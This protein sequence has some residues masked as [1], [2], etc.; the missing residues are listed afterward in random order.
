[1]TD[2]AG[3]TIR[4]EKRTFAAGTN[5]FDWRIEDLSAGMY[6]L[7]VENAEG[8]ASKKVVVTN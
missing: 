2:I 3:K 6:I 8:I 7:S 4:S 5:R 1:L